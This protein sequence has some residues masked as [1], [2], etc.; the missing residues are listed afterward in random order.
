MV[1]SS[2][3][4]H[5]NLISANILSQKHEIILLLC[6][7]VHP[8]SLLN[9]P[10]WDAKPKQWHLLGGFYT[11]QDQF[12]CAWEGVTHSSPVT[13]GNY[14]IHTMTPAAFP[15]ALVPHPLPQGTEQPR[16]PEQIAGISC[17][18]HR[19]TV[20]MPSPPG[21]VACI[22]SREKTPAL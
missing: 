21:L 8:V 2:E 3:S 13:R 10:E 1:T 19:F 12:L 14:A 11:L 5:I 18:T 16:A 7:Y 22:S 17:K 15:R 4:N 20:S 6:H 9:M